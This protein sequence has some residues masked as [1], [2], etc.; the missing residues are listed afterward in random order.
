MARLEEPRRRRRP[1][2]RSEEVPP[3]IIPQPIRRPVPR[4]TPRPRPRVSGAT[5]VRRLQGV[6]YSEGQMRIDIEQTDPLV[7][8]A[9]SGP[10]YNGTSYGV[11]LHPPYARVS[12]SSISGFR[13]NSATSDEF[14]IGSV[15]IML[16]PGKPMFYYAEALIIRESPSSDRFVVYPLE[17]TTLTTKA[18]TP[19]GVGI[20]MSQDLTIPSSQGPL[21][22]GARQQV[23]VL[24]PFV[25]MVS[26][27]LS[28]GFSAGGATSDSYYV[29]RVRVGNTV[30]P[31][32]VV[33][34]ES[35]ESDT[36]RVIPLQE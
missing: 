34:H 20:E 18:G 27:D 3:Q 19:L 36:Y 8:P 23:T 21:V 33:M 6:S 9:S 25:E 16:A 4:L 28:R 31:R 13:A 26:G 29:G 5:P 24:A 35:P 11:E 7:I 32:A 30:Y 1:G 17:Q 14:Y 15:D 22:D 12:T 2:S 10:V